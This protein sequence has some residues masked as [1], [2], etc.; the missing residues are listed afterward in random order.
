MARKK[1][2]TLTEAELR[3]MQVL[4]ERGPA[5]VAEVTEALKEEADLAYTTVLT[6]MQILERK[7]YLTH[8]KSG[9]AFVYLP[10]I[11][12]AEA[13]REALRDLVGRFFDNS[14]ELLVLNV[15]QHERISNKELKRLK[16]LI[17]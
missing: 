2:S 17:E 15:L 6:M 3:I 16:K 5:T 9:R 1:S 8:E 4:W 14:F 13:S 11:A 10:V 12:K 7:E